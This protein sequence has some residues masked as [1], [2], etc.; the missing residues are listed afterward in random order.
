MVWSYEDAL[1]INKTQQVNT[2]VTHQ[3]NIMKN[4]TRKAAD[5]SF[6]YLA[7]VK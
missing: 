4:K 3:K 6:Q 2:V 7:K 1:E 5:K